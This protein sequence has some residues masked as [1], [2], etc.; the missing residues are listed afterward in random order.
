[1]L[2]LDFVKTICYRA[3]FNKT[4]GLPHPYIFAGLPE[5]IFLTDARTYFCFLAPLVIFLSCCPTPRLGWDGLDGSWKTLKA[6]TYYKNV[7]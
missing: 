5:H 6:K 7:I 4:S 1:M 2:S 3:D